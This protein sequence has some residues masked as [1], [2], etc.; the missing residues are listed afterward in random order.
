MVCFPG[1]GYRVFSLV[2][3]LVVVLVLE[4]VALDQV[5]GVFL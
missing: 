5:P 2:L 3:L 1:A 4:N